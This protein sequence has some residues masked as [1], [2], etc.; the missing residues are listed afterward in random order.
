M[1]RISVS[2]FKNAEKLPLC[3]IVDSVR[4]LHNVGSFLRTAD[5]FRLEKVWLCGITGTPPNAEIHKTALGAEES[6]CWEYVANTS[7]LIERL[8]REGWQ[9]CAIEQVSGSHS[10]QDF[11]FDTQARYALIVGNEVMGVSQ[12]AVDASD[13][14]IEI[15]QFGT[16][17]SLNVSVTAG[18]LIWEFARRFEYGRRFTT[19]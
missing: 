14:C 2:D 4:S 7:E 8:S 6:V 10:L 9:I 3:L 11:P 19:P 1:Q 13:C 5:A 18:I 12:E 17:H 15:P 16:K